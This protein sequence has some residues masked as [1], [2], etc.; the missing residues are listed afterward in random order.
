MIMP[1]ISLQTN[2]EI[3]DRDTFLEDLSAL[4]SRELGK[5]ESYV[6]T[7]IDDGARM[8]FG[9]SADPCAFVRCKSIGLTESQ[10]DKL[11]KALCKFVSDTLG[12]PDDRVYIE[13]SGVPGSMWGWRGGT[14]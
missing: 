7:A 3:T 10:T 11:S 9:G 8:L 4:G 6:M 5:P 2:A 14:F 12:I 1:Y 13:F